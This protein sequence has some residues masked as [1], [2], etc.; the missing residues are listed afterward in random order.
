MESALPAIASEAA[1][2][3]A[4]GRRTPIAFVVALIARSGARFAAPQ[5]DQV[6]GV[7]ER[8]AEG[9]GYG[10]GHAPAEEPCRVDNDQRDIPDAQS[11]EQPDRIAAGVGR[12]EAC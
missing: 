1:R 4:S 12:K 7:K 2:I 3:P 10:K 8:A 5:L 11:V 6:V 9:E